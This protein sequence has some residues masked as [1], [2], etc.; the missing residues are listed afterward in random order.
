MIKCKE[1]LAFV[2][3]NTGEI[4]ERFELEFN[5]NELKIE[6]RRPQLIK[7]LLSKSL[8]E[9]WINGRCLWAYLKKTRGITGRDLLSWAFGENPLDEDEKNGD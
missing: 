7:K 8:E 2:N 5:S 9:K 1:Y 4:K 6:G 3:A